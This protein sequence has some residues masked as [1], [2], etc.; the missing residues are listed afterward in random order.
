MPGCLIGERSEIHRLFIEF[1]RDSPQTRGKRC[2]ASI[3]VSGCMST[4][5]EHQR[6]PARYGDC[7]S[8][9]PGFETLTAHFTTRPGSGPSW[10][11]PPDTP[12]TA[13]DALCINAG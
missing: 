6:E 13:S 9:G 4:L 11:R 12:Q 5:S 2:D 10:L 1:E 7:E 8:A 3:S